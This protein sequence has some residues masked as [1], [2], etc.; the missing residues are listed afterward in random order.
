M[1]YN[2]NIAS[3][4]PAGP[5][6][7]TFPEPQRVATYIS[8]RT[9]KFKMHSTLGLAKNAISGKAKSQYGAR[10]SSGARM[11]TARIVPCDCYV[12]VW[13]GGKGWVEFA[14]IPKDSNIDD[15]PFYKTKAPKVGTLPL[16]PEEEAAMIREL[17]EA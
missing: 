4:R 17:M 1:D 15:H 6:P 7:S 8:H 13:E 11:Q 5:D 14:F 10:N 9:D 12:Y 16:T 3:V 2:P